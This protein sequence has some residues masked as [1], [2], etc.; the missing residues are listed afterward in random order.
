MERDV[1]SARSGM[2]IADLQEVLGGPL[3]LDNRNYITISRDILYG[4]LPTAAVMTALLAVV[5]G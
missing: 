3:C 2:S 4:C 1:R 5:C